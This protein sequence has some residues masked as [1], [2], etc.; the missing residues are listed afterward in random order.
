MLQTYPLKASHTR[1]FLLCV[2]HL[3]AL[4]VLLISLSDGLK[5][6]FSL[7]F[8][9]LSFFL[10]LRLIPKFNQLIFSDDNMQLTNQMGN[11]L[12]GRVLGSTVVSQYVI[13]LH[14]KNPLS[15]KKQ[16]V[17]LFSDMMSKQDFRRLRMAI[18]LL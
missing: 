13:F 4:L 5:Q 12:E 17:L 9:P 6:L 15:A 14:L 8:I 10:Q 18:K 2:L 11:I 16:A 1:L 3:I 7:L